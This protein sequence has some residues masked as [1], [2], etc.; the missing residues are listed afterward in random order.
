MTHSASS[1]TDDNVHEWAET[2]AYNPK[3]YITEAERHLS[4]VYLTCDKRQVHIVFQKA[5]R[6]LIEN[7]LFGDTIRLL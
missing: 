1:G 4:W 3:G 7:H 5:N 6:Q 2:S